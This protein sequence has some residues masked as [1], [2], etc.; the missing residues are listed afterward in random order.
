MA[1]RA[2]RVSGMCIPRA[3]FARFNVAVARPMT[4]GRLERLSLSFLAVRASSVA[5]SRTAQ[6][7]EQRSEAA[8]P[9]RIAVPIR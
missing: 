7:A 4:N 5:A 2:R 3:V 8:T 6:G 9:F 1:G